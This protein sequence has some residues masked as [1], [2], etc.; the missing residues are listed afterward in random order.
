MKR[1]SALVLACSL[2]LPSAASAFPIGFEVKGGVGIGYYSMSEFKDHIQIIRERYGLEFDDPES[3]FNVMLEGRLWMLE[4]FAATAGYEH[5]W[6]DYNMPTGSSDYVSYKMPADVLSLGGTLHIYR[7]PKVIDFN[8]GV[9][10][11]FIKVVYGTDQDGRF[12]EYKANDYGWDIYGEVNT[13]FL[14]PLQVGF[15]LGYRSLKV[16][17]F[18]DKFGEA[19]QFSGTEAPV[20]V[21]YSGVYFYFTAG[22][23]IW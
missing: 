9:K 17:G 12:T 15:T 1:F 13:N 16:D 19:P 11:D 10:G 8:A 20:T 23:A 7:I 5:L 6:S 18:E 2:L 3:E 21:N 4:R 22:V 14:N